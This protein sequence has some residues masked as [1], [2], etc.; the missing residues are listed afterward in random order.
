MMENAVTSVA[1]PEV[2]DTAQNLMRIYRE[3]D[4]LKNPSFQQTFLQHNDFPIDILPE[5]IDDFLEELYGE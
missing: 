2:E 4:V 1:V 3:F 5:L